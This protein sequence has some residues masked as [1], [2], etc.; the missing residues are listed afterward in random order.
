MLSKI[1]ECLRNLDVGSS[2]MTFTA[3]KYARLMSFMALHAFI[4]IEVA[5]MNIFN[6]MA[7]EFE[8][9]SIRCFAMTFNADFFTEV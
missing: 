9:L 1:A 8:W 7:F 2:F 4:G 5:G 3:G 6:F